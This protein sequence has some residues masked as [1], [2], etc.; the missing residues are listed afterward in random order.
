MQ[1]HRL[2][3]C[4]LATRKHKVSQNLQRLTLMTPMDSN[5]MWQLTAKFRSK[6]PQMSINVHKCTVRHARVHTISCSKL[7]LPRFYTDIQHGSDISNKGN[8]G[9]HRYRCPGATSATKPPYREG[10]QAT[11]HF[12]HPSSDRRRSAKRLLKV[13]APLC[14]WTLSMYN[15]G[16]TKREA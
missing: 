7:A 9:S 8:Q 11:R 1:L 16:T 15:S 10:A 14:I 4:H 5:G 6:C 12:T 3:Q 13:Q 2:H